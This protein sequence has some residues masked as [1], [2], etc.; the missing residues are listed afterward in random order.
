GKRLDHSEGRR[1]LPMDPEVRLER[2]VPEVR[3]GPDVQVL[4]QAVGTVRGLRARLPLR[5]ARR[6]PGVLLAVHRGLAAD[7]PGRVAGGRVR[8]SVLG[9]PADLVPADDRRM[10]P[11]AAPD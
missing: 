2:A 5:R 8:P 11:A 6:W 9:P 1:S 10:R 7:L 4:A 3:Q